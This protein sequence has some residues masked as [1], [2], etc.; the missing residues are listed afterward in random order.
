MD[1]GLMTQLESMKRVA[2]PHE[3]LL[4]VDAMMGQVAIKVAG[5]LIKHR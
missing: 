4:V 3:L 5:R 2:K 1:E